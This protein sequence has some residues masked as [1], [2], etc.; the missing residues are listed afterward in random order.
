MDG[1][2]IFTQYSGISSCSLGS[3]DTRPIKATRTALEIIKASE[4][5]IQNS[6]TGKVT[7]FFA[8]TKIFDKKIG[9]S[10]NSNSGKLS[11]KPN[12]LLNSKKKHLNSAKS[13]QIGLNEPNKDANKGLIVKKKTI[14]VLLDT[15][16]KGE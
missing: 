5:L 15:G 13:H 1:R 14:R 11:I 2:K 16:S 9:N 10:R 3:T 7:A 6:K 12:K 8:I 4:K